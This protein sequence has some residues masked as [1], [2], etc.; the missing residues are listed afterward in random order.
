MK[1]IQQRRST[2]D[3]LEGEYGEG[4][5]GGSN[6][7]GSEP[8]SA[9]EDLSSNPMIKLKSKKEAETR[10]KGGSQGSKKGKGRAGGQEGER[11]KGKKK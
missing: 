2:T 1:K 11:K 5:D 7:N 4:G 9:D 8:D 10:G 6:M 3:S